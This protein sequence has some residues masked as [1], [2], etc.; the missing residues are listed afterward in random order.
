M[1][2]LILFLAQDRKTINISSKD[3]R[4]WFLKKRKTF[5]N[6]TSQKIRNAK[7]RK[8]RFITFISWKVA[9]FS[10]LKTCRFHSTKNETTIPLFPPRLSKN[11]FSSCSYLSFS[12]TNRVINECCH[13]VRQ[14]LTVSPSLVVILRYDLCKFRDYKDIDSKPWILS[15]DNQDNRWAMLGEKISEES[16]I[17]T[18][19]NSENAT[20]IVR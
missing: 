12:S 11:N 14:D 15:A 6:P 7:F 2:I 18:Y 5:F 9:L 20:D 17:R 1:L 3:F 4:H 13:N 10:V 16:S 19:I 8:E